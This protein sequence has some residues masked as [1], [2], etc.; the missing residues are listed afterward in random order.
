[1][2]ESEPDPM[3]WKQLKLFEDALSIQRHDPKPPQTIVIPGPCPTDYFGAKAFFSALD[4]LY[5]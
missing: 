1:M 5:C 2:S 3:P 4:E